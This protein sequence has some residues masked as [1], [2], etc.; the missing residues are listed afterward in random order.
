MRLL[1]GRSWRIEGMQWLIFVSIVASALSIYVPYDVRDPLLLIALIW[2]YRERHLISI[3]AGLKYVAV[4]MLAY[5]VIFTVLSTE[6]GRSLKGAYDMARGIL[7]FFIGYILGVK[8]QDP[9]KFIIFTLLVVVMI[10]ASF[11]LPQSYGEGKLFYGYHVNPNNAAVA[12]TIYTIFSIPMLESPRSKIALL[13]GI[14][15]IVAGLYLLVLTNSRG[16]WLG[17]FGASVVIIFMQSRAS[18]RFRMLAAFAVFSLFVGVLLFANYKGESLSYRDLIWSGLFRETVAT[19]PWLGFG[20][21][22]V[23]DVMLESG[24]PTLT[25]HNLF[26]EIFVSSGV[27]GLVFVVIV[28]AML[29]RHLMSFRYRRT[30]QFY[31]GIGG[32]TAYFLMAQ[33]DLKLSSFRFMATISLFLGLLYSQRLLVSGSGIGNSDLKKF[34][35]NGISCTS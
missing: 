8:L 19:H 22:R 14:M 34:K 35:V 24:L 20:I 15:G 27:I 1:H 21:N 2:S 3:D 23:K 10:L 12:L 33:F 25:A 17:I 4:L 7:V 30:A 18:M 9:E 13:L 11:Y 29:I 16:A 5:I 31:M 32:L 28:V 26:L 6:W